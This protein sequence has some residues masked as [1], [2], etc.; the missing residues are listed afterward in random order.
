MRDICASNETRG[1]D[2][3]LPHYLV[4]KRTLNLPSFSGTYMP[5]MQVVPFHTG[6]LYPHEYPVA[7]YTIDTMSFI[8]H[9]SNVKRQYKGSIDGKDPISS[10]WKE[11]E[12]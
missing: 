5:T 11:E 10:C 8:T 9:N 2:L 12:A 6:K 1:I 4:G 7:T 3:A